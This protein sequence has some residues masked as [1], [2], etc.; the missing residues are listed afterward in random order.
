[1]WKISVKIVQ[2]EAIM[3]YDGSGQNPRN[4]GSVKKLKKKGKELPFMTS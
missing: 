1:M 3:Q 2:Y 4:A